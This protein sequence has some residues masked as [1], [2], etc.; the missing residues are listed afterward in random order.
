MVNSYL[1]KVIRFIKILPV[2]GPFVSLKG[3]FDLLNEWRNRH[4]LLLSQ[5]NRKIRLFLKI[6]AFV[7]WPM[8]LTWT[9]LKHLKINGNEVK[10][11]YRKPL[12]KQW[13]EILYVGL[14]FNLS[15]ANYYYFCL[16]RPELIKYSLHFFPQ[17]ILD[18]YYNC[19]ILESGRC[20]LKDKIIF[21][22]LCAENKLPSIQNILEFRN[23][24]AMWLN[25]NKKLP[26]AD[27]ITKPVSGMLGKGLERWEYKGDGKGFQK[28][29][30]S[31][32]LSEK[33]LLERFLQLS[34]KEA[35]LAQP[36]LFSH[37]IFNNISNDALVTV[38]IV[39][40]MGISGDIHFVVANLNLPQGKEIANNLIDGAIA[41]PVDYQTGKTLEGFIKNIDFELFETHPITGFPIKGIVI[42]DWFQC[43]DMCKRAHLLMKNTVFI[44]WDVALTNDGPAIL[45]GNDH[46]SI[47]FHQIPPGQ[48]FANTIFPRI[49]VE[50]LRQV[51]IR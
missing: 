34:E 50:H 8:K 47:S 18:F 35:Y 21:S 42:P 24:A 32:F 26:K 6:A 39:T 27:I 40:A 31:E 22:R 1:E 12:M 4:T 46:P 14:K 20:E 23:G 44:G 17:I 36:R 49:L 7:V 51:E 11:K 15:P 43:I 29:G 19:K 25:T 33:G 9:S 3:N 5:Y 37:F 48:P 2:Y 41:C 45:E 10:N 30:S 16:F 28:T 13:L 38:R